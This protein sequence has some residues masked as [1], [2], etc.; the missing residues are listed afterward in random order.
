MVQKPSIL[1]DVGSLFHP[2]SAYQVSV[3]FQAK[4][5]KLPGLYHEKQLSDN[6]TPV[7]LFLF[8][9]IHGQPTNL[10]PLAQRWGAFGVQGMATL[11]A[12]EQI[13]T[14]LQF[15]AQISLVKIY[16]STIESD[17]LDRWCLKKRCAC[18]PTWARYVDWWA[19]HIV[20]NPST[21]QTRPSDV[22]GLNPGETRRIISHPPLLPTFTFD[23]HSMTQ[24]KMGSLQ[25]GPR[26]PIGHLPW[27]TMGVKRGRSKFQRSEFPDFTLQQFL[28]LVKFDINKMYLEAEPRN[29]YLFWTLLKISAW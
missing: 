25:N 17:G 27:V 5:V 2:L 28:K 22:G 24:Y 3:A 16:P 10:F 8:G 14:R 19:R 21:T 18:L 11:N 13:K 6:R 4:T 9:K 1:V 20:K 15:E 29:F 23:W 7:Y 12:C 26:G